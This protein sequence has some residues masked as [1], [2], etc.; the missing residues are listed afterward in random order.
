MDNERSGA[1][2]QNLFTRITTCMNMTGKMYGSYGALTPLAFSPD[3]REIYFQDWSLDADS[4]TPGI[5]AG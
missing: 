3:G 1:A 5:E 4:H 2:R